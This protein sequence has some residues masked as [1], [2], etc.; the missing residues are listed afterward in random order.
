MPDITSSFTDVE[1][2][3]EHLQN[4]T[5]THRGIGNDQ[6]P[7]CQISLHYFLLTFCQIIK[8]ANWKREQAQLLERSD[9]PVHQ[10]NTGRLCF[11]QFKRNE[12]III[13]HFKWRWSGSE[14]LLMSSLFLCPCFHFLDAP[15]HFISLVCVWLGKVLYNFTF[16]FLNNKI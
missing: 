10:H 2:K 11:Q 14:T 9:S 12:W 3:L 6:I 15:F 7:A 13:S 1:V 5:H 16:Q 4:A 8:Y